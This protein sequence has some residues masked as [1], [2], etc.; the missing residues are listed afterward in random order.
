MAVR[1]RKRQAAHGAQH[2]LPQRLW[3]RLYADFHPQI[4]RYFTTRRVQ[5]ADAEDLAM[6]V[7]EELGRRRIP[8][9]PEPYI[10]AI[11]RNVLSRYRRNKIRELAGLHR[12]LAEAAAKDGAG[13]LSGQERSE[14]SSR[15]AVE[16]I[17]ARLSARQL[18]MV[19][20]RFADNLS[21]AKLAVTL[22]CS[23]PAVYKRIQRLRRRVSQGSP[24]RRGRA[25]ARA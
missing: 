11:A 19:R 22:G 6:Q 9:D 16:A 25:L 17:A 2:R 20:L 4:E 23:Q 13:Y 14:A 5:R 7:F 12:L 21:I 10:R 15:D 8:R 3:A 1:G 18:E 24:W